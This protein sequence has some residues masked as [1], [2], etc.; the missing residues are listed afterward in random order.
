MAASNDRV[1]SEI[2]TVMFI[3]IVGYTKTTSNLN[4]DMFNEMHDVFDSISLP[5]FQKYS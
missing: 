3:D 5:M 1:T 2:L 4:R